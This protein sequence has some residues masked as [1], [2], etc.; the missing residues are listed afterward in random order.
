MNNQMDFENLP[1]IF[2]YENRDKKQPTFLCYIFLVFRRIIFAGITLLINGYPSLLAQT[3]SVQSPVSSYELEEIE[4]TGQKNVTAFPGVTR[5]LTVIQ[6][7][8]IAG[9]PAQ[10]LQELLEYSAAIDI[11][12]RGMQGVQADVSIR[13]GS[14]DQVLILLNGIPLSDPQTGHFNLDLPIGLDAIQ[15]I[16]ILNGPAAR[17]YGSGAFTGAINIVTKPGYSNYFKARLSAGQYG[18]H[19]IDLTSGLITGSARHMLSLGLSG[20]KGY[21]ENT[22]FSTMQA[23]YSGTVDLPEVNLDVQAGHQQKDFGA[24]GF[25]SPR[26]PGQYEEN[27]TSLISLKMKTGKTWI[28]RSSAY[29]RRKK[30]HFL[31]QRDNPGFYQNF[32]CNDVFGTQINTQIE[33]GRVSSLAG[34]EIRS[35]NILSTNLGMESIHPVKVRG[36]DSIYYTRQY[37]RTNLSYFQE[38]VFQ[39]GKATLTAGAMINWNSDNPDRLSVFPGLD[40]DFP[41]TRSV[42]SYVSLNRTLRFPTFTDMFYTDPSHQ[43]NRFLEPDQMV[44]LEGGLHFSFNYIKASVSFHSAFGKNIID[45]LWF[46]ETN[47]YSPVNLEN[48]FISGMDCMIEIPFHT[49]IHADFFLQNLS[50]GYSYLDASKSVPDSV[51]KYYNLKHKLNVSIRYRIFHRIYSSLQCSYQERLGSYQQYDPVDNYYMFTDYPPLFLLDASLSWEAKRFV[52][53]LDATNLMNIRYVDAGSVN[54]PGR[55]VMAGIK[56]N[57]GLGQKKG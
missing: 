21:M 33:T 43:G 45:W 19:Q 48:V 10:T 34:I 26:F 7:D 20:S 16:E 51:E 35:E 54:Q 38:H 9:A 55:W 50:I 44:S 30:D 22:D 13:G 36:E 14:F 53:Y 3:D 37:N 25:Y 32:H 47:R 23:Y 5:M 8:E 49:W 57:F 39:L 42:K 15:R 17:V 27:Q 41:I 12:Q 11:R 28:T 52:L 18:F 6:Q 24:N 40:F 2:L 31:L 29:W 1:L 4:V 56:I 46:Y